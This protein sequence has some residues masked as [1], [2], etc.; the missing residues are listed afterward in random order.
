MFAAVRI[1][2]GCI[3]FWGEKG[4]MEGIFRVISAQ[5]R[6]LSACNLILTGVR[7]LLLQAQ[8]V[9]GYPV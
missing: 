8:I 4:V 7:V 3:K 9:P 2:R 5:V 6:I 1:I